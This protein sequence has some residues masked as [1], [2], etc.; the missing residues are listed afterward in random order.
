MPKF[1]FGLLCS[2][3]FSTLSFGFTPTLST[4]DTLKTDATPLSNCGKKEKKCKGK[5]A[6]DDGTYE[7]EFKYGEPHGWGTFQYGNGDIYIGEFLDGLRDGHGQQNFSNDDNYAGEWRGGMIHGKGVYLWADKSKYV[8]TFVEGLMQGKGI[9]T[10]ANGES[11]DGEWHNGLADGQGEFNRQDGSRYVGH[12][13]A[14]KRDGSGVIT[15]RTGDVFIGKWKNGLANKKGTFQFNNG[16]KYMC[17][18]EDGEMSGEA[19]YI[20]VNGKEI[21]GN[22]VQ[23]EKETEG[24][25]ELQEAIGPNIGIAW[26]TVA[27][28]QMQ[29]KKYKLAKENLEI[30]RRFVTP[31]SDLNKLIYE[32]LQIIETLEKDDSL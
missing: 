20:M 12:H 30:A 27:M 29:G 15:F 24:N 14:G 3:L 16:D 4:I 9:I 11:Y 1:F 23:L 17:I 6:Y 13:K 32:Q 5:H 21:K 19:T 28:E 31:S 18:W 8:G 26:Y 2:L 10:L 7:G 22:L 25:E